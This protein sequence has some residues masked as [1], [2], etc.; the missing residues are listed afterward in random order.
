MTY[1]STSRPSRKL[2]VIGVSMISDLTPRQVAGVRRLQSRIGQAFAR[3]V[4][5]DD[6]LQH[7]ETFPEI[8]G[9]RRLDDFR[10]DAA[11]GSRSPPSSEPYRP[12]LC[13]RRGWR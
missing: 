3:A 6:V 4:G 7:V 12:G 2:A 5:G 10:S 13:A 8:G 11:S 1:C 9:D